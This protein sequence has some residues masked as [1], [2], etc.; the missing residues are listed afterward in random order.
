MFVSTADTSIVL[1]KTEVKEVK[2]DDAKD[3]RVIVFSYVTM[4][5]FADSIIE[6]YPQLFRRGK[7]TWDQ[8][9]DGWPNI[10]FEHLSA[11]EHRHVMF[12][13]SLFESKTLFEQLSMVMVLPRQFVQS[14]TILFPYFAPATM[15]RVEEEGV[16][17]TAETLA[18]IISSCIPMTRSG[19]ATLR[20]FDIHALPVRFY[21][22]DNVMMRLMSAIPLL[23]QALPPHSTIAFPDDGAAKRFKK[24]FNEFP[25]IV[26]S[27]VREGDKRSIKISDKLNW[28]KDEK[29]VLDHVVIVD[30][31][32]Q[33]GGT[34][35]ECRLALQQVGAKAVSAYVTHSV[36]PNKGYMK[37]MNGG[38]YYG[39]H[40]FYT[41]NT[42]TEISNQL[43]N[44]H[45]FVVLPIQDLL[46][47][48]IRKEWNL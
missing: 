40:K 37:F 41:T 39:F 10:K 31:L 23:I 6:K 32:V 43:Q 34:L 22:Q 27:K 28:P 35:H 4:N 5:A 18:K 1:S 26:C 46:V 48:D 20:I 42:I 45:P 25:I 33:T 9:A 8:F 30:D 13:G 16:L 12:I 36:F 38:S 11:L 3:N 21:F 2:K 19:P 14:L 47:G 24:M 44:Q 17:A 7:I 15:E 29:N